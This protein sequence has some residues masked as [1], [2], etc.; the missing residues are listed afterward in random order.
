M[1]VH[2]EVQPVQSIKFSRDQ[3][4][5]TTQ[6]ISCKSEQICN[7]NSYWWYRDNRNIDNAYWLTTE[8]QVLNNYPGIAGEVYVLVLT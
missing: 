3:S 1:F 8:K 4:E 6:P 5:S 2:I 7:N